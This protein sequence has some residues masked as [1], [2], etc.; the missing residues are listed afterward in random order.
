MSDNT[1]TAVGETKAATAAAEAP[2]KPEGIQNGEEAQN[3]VENGAAAGDK[4]KTEE[5]VPEP[6]KK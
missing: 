3:G 5:G 2:Y 1:Q 4:R 6:E